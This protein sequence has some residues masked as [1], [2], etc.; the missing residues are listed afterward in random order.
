MFALKWI[1][2]IRTLTLVF[3]VGDGMLM[4]VSYMCVNC[5]VIYVCPCVEMALM[6]GHHSTHGFNI[7]TMHSYKLGNWKYTHQYRFVL[8]VW[9]QKNSS[10]DWKL[11]CMIICQLWGIKYMYL[12]AWLWEAQCNKFYSQ[13]PLK[14][15]QL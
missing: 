6:T 13:S 8:M 7:I 9:K 15:T 11:W 1:C 4:S 5:H 12:I 2:Q 3:K 14:P 10:V